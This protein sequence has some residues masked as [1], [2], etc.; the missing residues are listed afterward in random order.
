MFD[1]RY[2]AMVDY[3]YEKDMDDEELNAQLN[4]LEREQKKSA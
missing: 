1:D 3:N 2:Y 4:E